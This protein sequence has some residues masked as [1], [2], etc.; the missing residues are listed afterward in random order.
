[1]TMNIPGEW[2]PS[3]LLPEKLI[4]QDINDPYFFMNLHVKSLSAA[5]ILRE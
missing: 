4:F 3:S 1:M 2:D 5:V